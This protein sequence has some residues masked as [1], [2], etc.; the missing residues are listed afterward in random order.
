MEFGKFFPPMLLEEIEEPF[1]SPNFLFEL[2]FDG[3]RASIHVGPNTFKI[4]GR[5]GHEITTLYPELKSIQKNFSKNVIFDGEIVLFY[6][7]KPNF[8]KLQERM[9]TKDKKRIEYFK[10]EMPVCFMVFDCLCENGK[11]LTNKPLIERKKVLQK[12]QDM[13]YFI[14]VQYIEKEGKKLFSKVKKMDFEGI[15]AKKMDSLYEMNTRSDAWIKIKNLKKEIFYIG[16]FIEKKENAVVSLLLGEYQHNDFHFVG[17]VTMGK[18]QPMYQKLIKEKI[19][20]RT[21][22]CDYEEK[23]CF[24]VNPHLQCEVWYLERTEENKLRQPVFKR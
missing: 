10:E 3:V 14:K 9:H 24:Y 6:H 8:S 11:D 17:K 15:V 7:G 19:R 22:F 5:S 20:K 1:D 2:K 12:Y 18:K 13:D 23:E 4:F 16:G 21:P